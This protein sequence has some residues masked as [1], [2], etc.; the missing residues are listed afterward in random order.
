MESSRRQQAQADLGMDFKKEDEKRQAA[1]AKEQA[2]ASAKESKRKEMMSM[3]SYRCMSATA[4]YMDK[5]CLDP[6]IGL[7]P[8]GIG[9]TLSSV[10]A[11]PF[12]YY[13]LCVVKSIPLTLAVIYNVL[14]DIL[15]GAI[16]FFIGDIFD[17]FH[18]SYLENLRLI[19]GYINDDKEIIKTVNQKAFKTAILIALVCWLIYLVISWAISLGHWIGSL[20]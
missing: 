1:L 5:W 12:I 13:S 20:F 17:F 8:F 14:K 9:D 6:V 4:K 2:R 19:T 16:P 10:L 11:L 15:L 3:T 7:L 18:R